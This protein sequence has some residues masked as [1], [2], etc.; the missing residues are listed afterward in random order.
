MN[1]KFNKF[2]F[3]ATGKD[4]FSF[5]TNCLIS[6]ALLTSSVT[7]FISSTYLVHQAYQAQ[8]AA[9]QIDPVQAR[10]ARI[11][12][13]G[14][15]TTGGV[16]SSANSVADSDLS[17][18]LGR[19]LA[20][21][22]NIIIEKEAKAISFQGDLP[23]TG[24]RVVSTEV[25]L[26]KNSETIKANAYDYVNL[27]YVQYNKQTKE[28]K[29]VKFA[30]PPGLF[31]LTETS[32]N[33]PTLKTSG[34]KLTELFP[35]R[36]IRNA[37][38]SILGKGSEEAFSQEDWF[39]AFDK[40]SI[41]LDLSNSALSS[42]A[43]IFN[44]NLRWGLGIYDLLGTANSSSRIAGNS[45]FEIRYRGLSTINV[46][47]NIITHFPNPNYKNFPALKNIR[48]SRNAIQAIGNFNTFSNNHYSTEY[49]TT[50]E[51][52]SS[53]PTS[54]D[55]QNY[56][57]YLKSL[58][59]T[60]SDVKDLA[61]V[62][63]V[64]KWLEITL[65]AV[66]YL[67]SSSSSVSKTGTKSITDY[68]S[69]LD[70]VSADPFYFKTRDGNKYINQSTTL[71]AN[72][73]GLKPTDTSSSDIPYDTTSNITTTV[74]GT[75]V[76]TNS[77]THFNLDKGINFGGVKLDLSKDI[78]RIDF[79]NNQ[80]E[81]IPLS[82]NMFTN[83]DFSN[84]RLRYITPIAAKPLPWFHGLNFLIANLTSSFYNVVNP[85]NWIKY[86]NQ[87]NETKPSNWTSQTERIFDALK[88]GNY[89]YT[90]PNFS[91]YGNQLLDFWP[92]QDTNSS[93]YTW[94]KLTIP[95]SQRVQGAGATVNSNVNGYPVSPW[96]RQIGNTTNEF[97]PWF[98]R[99]WIGTQDGNN[100][101]STYL[102]N[103]DGNFIHDIQNSA[104]GR[105]NSN[106]LYGIFFNQLNDNKILTYLQSYNKTINYNVT[107]A[108]KEN[109]KFV[110]PGFD[111]NGE[112]KQIGTTATPVRNARSVSRTEDMA[113]ERKAFA[114]NILQTTSDAYKSYN[115]Q[116]PYIL[117][118]TLPQ[119]HSVTNSWGRQDGRNG[120]GQSINVQLLNQNNE[121]VADTNFKNIDWVSLYANANGLQNN[122][123]FQELTAE[124]QPSES[125]GL[126]TAIV[127]QTPQVTN[128]GYKFLTEVL[129]QLPYYNGRK[130]ATT[131]S[132]ATG[133]KSLGIDIQ[134]FAETSGTNAVPKS[135]SFNLII[136][137][138][139]QEWTYRYTI[140]VLTDTSYFLNAKNTTGSDRTFDVS[141]A[142]DFTNRFKFASMISQTDLSNN[143]DQWTSGTS[144]IHNYIRN[145]SNA[146]FIKKVDLIKN[147]IVVGFDVNDP[148]N[149]KISIEDITLT[150][151]PQQKVFLINNDKTVTNFD[152]ETNAPKNFA[153]KDRSAALT[154]IKDH[155]GVR[156]IGLERTDGKLTSDLENPSASVTDLKSQNIHKL[157]DLKAADKY[158]SS[159]FF[160]KNDG[161]LSFTLQI[162][163]NPVNGGINLVEN[164]TIT[165]FKK[166]S[167]SINT[168]NAAKNLGA[169]EYTDNKLKEFVTL[170]TFQ[171]IQGTEKN[172]VT[173]QWTEAETE[174]K[175]TD[176]LP[177]ETQLQL[178]D[179]NRN[180]EVGSVD[181]AVTLSETTGSHQVID[182]RTG[183]F[184]GLSN[185]TSSFTWKQNNDPVSG[186]SFI[187]YDAYKDSISN[188]QTALSAA[189]EQTKFSE[190]LFPLLDFNS[191]APSFATTKDKELNGA[192]ALDDT[193][194]K[195]L[196][197]GFG[198]VPSH[199]RDTI[200]KHVSLRTDADLVEINGLVI[201]G[202]YLNGKFYQGT[203]ANAPITRL[204]NL[205]VAF[206]P[207]TTQNQ[208]IDDKY[209][210]SAT[211]NAT[212]KPDSTYTGG[213]SLFHDALAKQWKDLLPSEWLAELRRLKNLQTSQ[214]PSQVNY[215]TYDNLTGFLNHVL[216]TSTSNTSYQTY[217]DLNDFSGIQINNS[218]GE[219]KI[220]ANTLFV[221]NVYKNSAKPERNPA[222]EFYNQPISFFLSNYFFRIDAE[223]KK[224]LPFAA[225]VD[226]NRTFANESVL[227]IVNQLQDLLAKAQKLYNAPANQ[228][229]TGADLLAAEDA[230]NI[231]K[232][233]FIHPIYYTNPD[234]ERFFTTTFTSQDVDQTNV[235]K[236]TKF[237]NLAFSA[238]DYNAGSLT[239]KVQ[240]ENYIT[241]LSA[242]H[243]TL[244]NKEQTFEITNAL[245]VFLLPSW[246]NFTESNLKIR[247]DDEK[248]R[249]LDGESSSGTVTNNQFQNLTVEEY[250]QQLIHQIN[251]VNN[252]YVEL[253][254]TD[255]LLDLV[256]WTLVDNTGIAI[257]NQ[258]QQYN[259]AFQILKQQL[260]KYRFSF[261]V[262][263][264]DLYYSAKNEQ[265]YVLNPFLHFHVPNATDQQT[266]ILKNIFDLNKTTQS[267]ID[268]TGNY[269]NV[270]LNNVI[271]Q[272]FK[273]QPIVIHPQAYDQADYQL[274]FNGSFK[275]VKDV[276]G[277]D[278]LGWLRT[279]LHEPAAINTFLQSF[280]QVQ[281]FSRPTNPLSLVLNPRFAQLLATQTPV[282][283]L[284]DYILIND[285][286]GQ[287][288][289]LA[290]SIQLVNSYQTTVDDLN[291]NP[292][293]L[294][295]FL[296]KF[297]Q[298]Q[299]D[300][301]QLK[302]VNTGI[303]A[304]T[305]EQI[306]TDLVREGIQA[307]IRNTTM[308]LQSD[309]F[310]LA[311]RYLQLS[312]VLI[313]E[314]DQQRLIIRA[315]QSDL[316]NNQIIIDYE[317]ENAFVN[318]QVKNL[319]KQL[320]LTGFDS[321]SHVFVNTHLPWIM[322][323][324]TLL[325]V[326]IYYGIWR[327]RHTTSSIKYMQTTTQQTR[328]PN[329]KLRQTKSKKQAE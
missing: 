58:W 311:Y 123:A 84:N 271:I 97:Y 2:V 13:S 156:W 228:P 28:L 61:I 173:K 122:L 56:Y 214:L 27:K 319:Q 321:N 96:N 324:L 91:F 120:P 301:T 219:V 48:A 139:T 149:N 249:N 182:V 171:T 31:S 106:N 8:Q 111:S 36:A 229:L 280:F 217:V 308:A 94:P 262:R 270:G 222:P 264:A 22:E 284:T 226:V 257:S 295:P 200:K 254:N 267:L 51:L 113:P 235:G 259:E 166:F 176:F 279:N 202:G 112:L 128:N 258:H 290:G 114:D 105:A 203:E 147:E 95:E 305:T 323:L 237:T 15:T 88:T 148:N 7:A 150:G 174:N 178:T 152:D 231:L 275:A 66:N 55:N 181:F 180:D 127:G 223:I 164:H 274:N 87:D 92:Q 135:P 116:V 70:A 1:P 78:Y 278:I 233:K 157:A 37:V 292:I 132:G 83:V 3:G 47:D 74:D 90:L 224:Q 218:T 109:K 316:V 234:A 282:E 239:V 255:Q 303:V 247:T 50:T 17:A 186:I 283:Q 243:F 80:I 327:H 71:S 62:K 208:A 277:A 9:E 45:N 4:R 108:K 246:K 205:L 326:G 238:A 325:G 154:W 125:N 216:T 133:N 117:T 242:G 30:P 175:L 253:T 73:N 184:F 159:V 21:L 41:T 34:N 163:A 89:N 265:I 42:I 190:L 268:Q 81:R 269:V 177:P 251:P 119:N 110:L 204:P 151:F 289:F 310:A 313:S 192:T 298:A 201:K 244:A 143:I 107:I 329:K 297:D 312:E 67:G 103:F 320:V 138:P 318:G 63:G 188:F 307:N 146:L 197:I 93:W 302:L 291:P 20:D 115:S 276:S 299:I 193:K 281:G 54:Q 68:S 221:N 199:D 144:Y 286:I 236:M 140:N 35:T 210:S 75:L 220:A 118:R 129:G 60:N 207:N 241:G 19:D 179:V 245:G 304:E 185:F 38:G 33:W 18:F 82:K 328:A 98:H 32:N 14:Q 99:V 168:D 158:V 167:F 137:A 170:K 306:T 25:S 102:G 211:P 212:N 162:N 293:S 285:G 29:D 252:D 100:L 53:S 24:I 121:D 85:I 240:V 322:V 130:K 43:E 288:T 287:L 26:T 256:S 52:Q 296:A 183:S 72:K 79:S 136:S 160:N 86:Y 101:F 317:I 57:D 187:N 261:N 227:G 153:S 169:L 314:N 131:W 309:Q 300:L 126:P 155:V 165:T 195:Q 260:E 315:I 141:T 6:L 248:L 225:N 69:F 215:Q 213:G 172:I 206:K 272:G 230:I 145:N 49:R 65:P 273:R 44:P 294:T 263:K 64:K 232:F 40:T 59:D 104:G 134:T 198:S 46:E 5:S 124:Y 266:E 11:T 39:N 142:S 10:I 16:S 77:S 194:Q 161:T 196:V 23:K 191:A 189:T 76:N 209:K 250:Y 12:Q